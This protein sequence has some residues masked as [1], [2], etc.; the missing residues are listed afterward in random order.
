M[1]RSIRRTLRLH[2]LVA[3]CVGALF[4][5]LALTAEDGGRP[6]KPRKGALVVISGSTGSVLRFYSGTNKADE[7]GHAVSADNVPGAEPPALMIGAPGTPLSSADAGSGAVWAVSPSSGSRELRFDAETLGA[8]PLFGLGRSVLNMGHINSD[9]FAWWAL[10]APASVE[11]TD[12]IP[13][14]VVLAAPGAAQSPDARLRE[15][16]RLEGPAA[17]LFG[18][19]TIV[20]DD[21]TGD[22]NPEL[23]VGAP[24]LNDAAG[25]VFVFSS[26]DGQLL[27]SV[28]GTQ[29][30][31]HFGWELARTCDIDA[32]G[33]RD[34]LVGAPGIGT[35]KSKGAVVA[36]S[37]ADGR[38]LW[39]SKGKAKQR[40]YGFSLSKVF[41]VSGENWVGA[42]TTGKDDA[43]AILRLACQTGKTSQQLLGSSANQRFGIA[44][45]DYWQDAQNPAGLL[46]VGSQVNDKK[47]KGKVS[48]V[49]PA[50]GERLHERTGRK[51]LS[52]LGLFVSE[53][54][55]QDQDGTRDYL[56]AELGVRP[57]YF[58][59][60]GAGD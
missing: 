1:R 13:A 2:L 50:T 16:Y 25:A 26:A 24:L 21:V 52:A 20:T 44:L 23:V 38:V 45:N 3:L 32:D 56:A 54:F 47:A 55:D 59:G 40:H 29:K 12:E 28:A 41:T 43:G 22:G 60:E 37:S 19:E 58:P 57:F 33:M 9:N 10:G 39:R 53:V 27:Y 15:V 48:L 51:K 49:N 4:A 14:V 42:P 31:G 8:G 11:P 30:N 46:I 6:P 36:V 17:S 34:F 5:P 35:K 18:W 7:F